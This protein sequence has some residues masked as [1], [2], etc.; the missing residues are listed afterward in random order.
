MTTSDQLLAELPDTFRYSEART[1]LN[2]RQFRRLVA[3]RQIVALARGL[4]RK[5]DS[6][7]DDDLIEVA[8]RSPRATLCLRSALAKHD[9]IDDIP[10]EID[11]AIPR[12]AWTPATGAPVRW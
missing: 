5:G 12:G 6:V 2:E 11:I 4:Y 1:K 10:A 7:G 8:S 9:L 3:E